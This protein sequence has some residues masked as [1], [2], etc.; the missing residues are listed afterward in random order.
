MKKLFAGFLGAA[1]LALLLSGC[2]ENDQ[3]NDDSA[4]MQALRQSSVS[5][6]ETEEQAPVRYRLEKLD[7]APDV[8]VTFYNG[9]DYGTFIYNRQGCIM[10][11]NGNIV[12]KN[13]FTY[14]EDVNG[15]NAIV[16]DN[17][18]Y[19]LM[20]LQSASKIE[21]NCAASKKNDQSY[22]FSQYREKNY[23]FLSNGYILANRY[24]NDDY[25]LDQII[26]NS[27]GEEVFRLTGINVDKDDKRIANYIDENHIFI[28]KKS[29]IDNETHKTL[30]MINNKSETI[31]EKNVSSGTFFPDSTDSFICCENEQKLWGALDYNGNEIIPFKYDI[32][33]IP[34]DGM[35]AVNQ[36]GKW[37]FIDFA[38]N[39][40]IP[41]KYQGK[42]D[43]KDLMIYSYFKN[44][45]AVVFDQNITKIIDKQG[46]EV[47][48]AEAINTN[49]YYNKTNSAVLYNDLVVVYKVESH[50]IPKLKIYNAQNGEVLYDTSGEK[51][52]EKLESI[53]EDMICI[54]SSATQSSSDN[55]VVYKLIKE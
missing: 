31:W 15:N 34:S 16:K 25:S 33:S 37:G 27:E 4:F 3:R 40:V 17:D 51:V 8:A 23:R 55:Y 42:N 36:F 11:K 5:D 13:V 22:Y 30:S 49:D 48:T 44:N 46:N 43:L 29:V 45:R 6:I 26:L 47:F 2:G 39:E 41:P 12:H 21:L 18:K 9:C 24:Y 19:Y 14:V 10:D 32:M 35:I 54:K 28:S 1:L 7:S 38:G 20:D 50:E 52:E 53:C